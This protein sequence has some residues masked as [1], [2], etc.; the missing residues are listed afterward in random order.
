METLQIIEQPV[1]PRRLADI[2]QGAVADGMI[3]DI[4]LARRFDVVMVIGHPDIIHQR[5]ID[6]RL[7]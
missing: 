5:R 6:E 2:V 7:V 1:T 3:L 4:D